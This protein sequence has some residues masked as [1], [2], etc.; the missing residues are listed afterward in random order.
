MPDPK[1]TFDYRK[2]VPDERLPGQSTPLSLLDGIMLGVVFTFFAIPSSIAASMA[3][4]SGPVGFFFAWGLLIA[5]AYLLGIMLSSEG[6]VRA[7]NA[8]LA[9]ALAIF[10]VWLALAI[11]LA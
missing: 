11:R 5:L 10:T 4:F 2:D 7:A 6:S 1:P 9:A 8:F 3:T